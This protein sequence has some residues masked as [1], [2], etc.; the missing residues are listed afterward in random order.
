MR[1]DKR[2]KIERHTSQQV[3]VGDIENV[4]SVQAQKNKWK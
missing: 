4:L 2:C 3:H 1:Q